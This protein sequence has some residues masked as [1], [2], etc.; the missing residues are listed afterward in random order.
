M[1]SRNTLRPQDPVKRKAFCRW[2]V[3]QCDADAKFITNCVTSDGAILSLHSETNTTH[4]AMCYAP[5]RNVHPVG[6]Y[7]GC[8]QCATQVMVWLGMAW[9]ELEDNPMPSSVILQIKTLTD[10]WHGES[11]ILQYPTK[12]VPDLSTWEVPWKGHRQT[13]WCTQHPP[14]SKVA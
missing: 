14:P 2:Y 3:N 9:P 11:R 6:H 10:M 4:N 1:I 12:P 8:T 7:V 5:R 13:W